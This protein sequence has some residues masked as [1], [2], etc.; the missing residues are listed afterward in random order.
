MLG[1]VST[2]K[3]AKA[4]TRVRLEH[5]NKRVTRLSRSAIL[6]SMVRGCLDSRS[7]HIQGTS[8]SG[9]CSR[10][11]VE[12]LSPILFRYVVAVIYLEF[13]GRECRKLS[14]HDRSGQIPWVW[15]IWLSLLW[16]CLNDASASVIERYPLNDL[17]KCRRIEYE[18]ALDPANNFVHEVQ[19]PTPGATSIRICNNN[20]I[21]F[22]NHSGASDHRRMQG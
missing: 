7:F 4:I 16:R 21:P 9:A 5:L 17:P 20:F 15:T 18:L 13:P 12:S 22:F 1:P 3:F 11:W 2:T 14:L 8:L 10:S 19:T 6:S